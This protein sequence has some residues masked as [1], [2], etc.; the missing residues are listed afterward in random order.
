[1]SLPI[2]LFLG[3]AT[4]FGMQVGAWFT[5]QLGAF[6]QT[7]FVSIINRRA[8]MLRASTLHCATCATPCIYTCTR[9]GRGYTQGGEAIGG[10]LPPP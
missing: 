7:F 5:M 1:M 3:V 2:M 10:E 6:L 4:G 9:C 8:T